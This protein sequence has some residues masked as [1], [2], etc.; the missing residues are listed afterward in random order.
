MTVLYRSAKLPKNYESKLLKQIAEELQYQV[1]RVDI[2]LLKYWVT[3]R[4]CGELT[5]YFITAA[6]LGM[7]DEERDLHYLSFSRINY[8]QTKCLYQ[9]KQY[10]ESETFNIENQYENCLSDWNSN[11]YLM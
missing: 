3:G 4:Y 5:Y 7:L 6:L 11:I 9:I 10:L 8:Y 2:N 1:D